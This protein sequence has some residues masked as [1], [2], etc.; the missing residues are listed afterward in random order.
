VFLINHQSVTHQEFGAQYAAAH[1]PAREQT[2]VLHCYAKTWITKLEIRSGTRLFLRVG[3]PEFV[4]DNSLRV[5]DICLFELKQNE[6]ELTME[7]H[8]I[9][10][11]QF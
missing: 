1:L 9:P 2:M 4:H 11:E 5:G 8:I 3:W 7:V 6:K 10:M